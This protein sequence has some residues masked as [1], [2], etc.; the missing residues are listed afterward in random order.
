MKTI[1][2]EEY[3]GKKI[4]K[5]LYRVR[6]DGEILSANLGWK[7][8]SKRLNKDGYYDLKLF[9]ED[10]T[11]IT[12]TVHRLVC[13]FFHELDE[14][15]IDPT[16]NHKDGDKTNNNKNNLEWISHVDNGR[17]YWETRGNK[18]VSER[19]LELALLVEYS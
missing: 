2:I 9:L 4:R 5:D 18:K 15:I 14:D 12:E 7:P 11:R 1:D 13:Y 10:G 3:R 6:E 19:M 16:V 17:H 8:K